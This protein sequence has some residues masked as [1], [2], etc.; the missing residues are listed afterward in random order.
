MA[1]TKSQA[2]EEEEGGHKRTANACQRTLLSAR[3]MSSQ[4]R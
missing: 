3:R 4:A 1:E 2:G